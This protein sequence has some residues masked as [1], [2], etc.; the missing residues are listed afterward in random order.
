MGCVEKFWFDLLY[1]LVGGGEGVVLQEGADMAEGLQDVFDFFD[2]FG[3][4]LDELM[5][6]ETSRGID[7]AP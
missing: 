7:P 4:V 2:H 6:S 1:G 5:W 3:A